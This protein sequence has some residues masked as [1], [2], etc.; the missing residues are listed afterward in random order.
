[1][2]EGKDLM[3]VGNYLANHWLDRFDSTDALIYVVPLPAYCQNHSAFTT[4]LVSE[5]YASWCIVR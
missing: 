3:K 1:M 5:M 2:K 4:P